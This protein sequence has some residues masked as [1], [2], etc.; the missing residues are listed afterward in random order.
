MTDQDRLLVLGSPH[1]IPWLEERKQAKLGELIANYRQGKETGHQ[2]AEL[3]VLSELISILENK[4]R[5]AQ[6]KGTP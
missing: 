3:S 2:Q 1:Y 6:K 5:S 4:Q